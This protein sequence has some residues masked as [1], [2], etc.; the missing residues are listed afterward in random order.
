MSIFP[1]HHIFLE[2]FDKIKFNGDDPMYHDHHWESQD[3]QEYPSSTG[4]FLKDSLDCRNITINSIGQWRSS[5]IME[6]SG[7]CVGVCGSV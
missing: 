7:K 4:R 2:T 6:D 5:S 1:M 3:D